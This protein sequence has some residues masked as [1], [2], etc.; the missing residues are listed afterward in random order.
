MDLYPKS[1][2]P[3]T[4]DNIDLIN[5]K[6]NDDYITYPRNYS[7]NRSIFD[8]VIILKKLITNELK[9]GLIYSFAILGYSPKYR[10]FITYGP[11]ILITNKIV[12][13]ILIT[14]IKCKI[15]SSVFDLESG[16][17]DDDVKIVFFKYKV[18]SINKYLIMFQR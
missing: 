5:Y 3:F 4:L 6:F 17:V 13:K 11:H 1:V 18:I 2:Y 7:N 15:D 10:T 9:N 16:Y 8:W 14:Y 12:I